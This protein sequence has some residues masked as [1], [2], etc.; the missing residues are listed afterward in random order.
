[1]WGCPTKAQ[2]QPKNTKNAFF[3]CFWAYVRQPHNHISWATPMPFAS[4]NSSSPRTNPW[5]FQEKILRIGRAGEWDFY[6]AAILNFH[7]SKNQWFL[8]NL[9]KEAVRTN[10]QMTVSVWKLF[11]SKLTDLYTVLQNCSHPNVQ[12]FWLTGP[13][14]N[15]FDNVF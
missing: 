8:Q 10:K 6:E 12:L 3:A 4:I 14:V 13:Q 7:F 11:V 15:Q 5:N 2:K 1:M 9:G